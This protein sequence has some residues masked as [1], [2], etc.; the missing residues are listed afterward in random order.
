MR[1]FWDAKLNHSNQFKLRRQVRQLKMA[2]ARES[3]D[4]WFCD[5]C[6]VDHPVRLGDSQVTPYSS[7]PARGDADDSPNSHGWANNFFRHRHLQ[8]IAKYTRSQYLDDGRKH[9]LKQLMG[10]FQSSRAYAAQTMDGSPEKIVTELCSSAYRVI[11]K[12]LIEWHAFT[13]LLTGIATF[14]RLLS[15]VCLPRTYADMSRYGECTPIQIR[16]VGS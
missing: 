11:S 9:H 8:M 7:C 16:L 4:V 13:H 5:V 2:K 14:R 10:P 15:R 12:R 6:I 3:L 1:R